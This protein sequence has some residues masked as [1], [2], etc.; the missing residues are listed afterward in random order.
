M[1]GGWP[2]I[3]LGTLRVCVFVVAALGLVAP[4]VLAAAGGS[5]DATQWVRLPQSRASAQA[6][7]ASALP[8]QWALSGAADPDAAHTLLFVVTPRGLDG[9]EAALMAVSDPVR[10]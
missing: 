1:C 3:M 10:A 5:Q 9:L 7:L 4:A 2:L 6:L 8:H